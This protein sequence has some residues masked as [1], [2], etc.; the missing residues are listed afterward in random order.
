MR[1]RVNLLLT[2]LLGGLWHGADWTFVLWG[3]FHG[4]YL[5]FERLARRL[6]G[7]PEK[8]SE[9]PG[10]LWSLLGRVW[11]F[12]VVCFAWILFRAPSLPIAGDLLRGLCR[13]ETDCR[14]LTGRAL[15]L[16]AVGFALQLLDGT[17]LRSVWD[18]VNRWPAWVQGAVAAVILTLILGVGPS[19][20]APF[21]YFQF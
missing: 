7:L 5:S 6:F 8:P 20:V 19:G 15:L 4:V 14:L 12:H 2:F 3:A 21:I 11:I 9:N 16:L 10:W 1:T 17:R 13:W 18:R